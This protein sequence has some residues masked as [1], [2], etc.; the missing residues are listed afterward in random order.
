MT[1]SS[2]H[3]KNYRSYVDAS[4]EFG[5][6]VNII[7]GPN[8]IGKTNL[9]EAL[10]LT[11]GWSA[12][13]R[14]GDGAVIQ[15]DKP[16]AR[17]DINLNDDE[18]R[19]V[20]LVADNG[21]VV[22]EYLINDHRHTYLKL[23]DSLPV[24][25]FEPND[26]RL[27]TGPPELRRELLDSLLERTEP[28]Y[29]KLLRDYRR[30]HAQRNRLLKQGPAAAKQ[31]FIWDVRLSE[32][33]ANMVSARAGLAR[34]FNDQLSATYR[35]IAV[36]KSGNGQ[37]IYSSSCPPGDQ[38]ASQLLNLLQASQA[39]DILRGFTAHGPHRDDFRIELNGHNAA[40]TASRGE[41]RSLILALKIIE[42][43]IVNRAR[44]QKPLLMLDDVFS[45]LDGARRRALTDALSGHQAFITTTD[46]DLALQNLS[47]ES[48]VIPINLKE[49]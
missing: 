20:K 35:K 4:F 30:T 13:W 12:S 34:Q 32:L 23:D 15:H 27:L 24:V 16:W 18:Q 14:S 10:L 36:D 19:T 49:L 17:L 21:K 6:Q 44:R 2:I 33:G 29:A 38:Y 47:A 41:T 43:E 5:K 39:T 40:L 48:T 42:I 11:C 46:A 3:L 1:I 8:A 28:N 31:L 25:F 22:K 26:M 7:V 45:E 9:L 37:F